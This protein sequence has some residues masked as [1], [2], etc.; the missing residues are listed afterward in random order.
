MAGSPFVAEVINQTVDAYVEINRRN[1]NELEAR[2]W[3]NIS[4]SEHPEA[5]KVVLQYIK[6]SRKYWNQSTLEQKV[7][8]IQILLSPFVADD[9]VMLTL[10]TDGDLINAEDR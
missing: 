7:K 10:I 6:N 5:K 2:K 1:F 3:E 4:I 8:Y 9:D